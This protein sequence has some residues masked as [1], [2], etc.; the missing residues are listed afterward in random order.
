MQFRDRHLWAGG[1][2]AATS[3]NI[4]NE[5]IAEYIK[6]Q[7]LEERQKGDDFEVDIL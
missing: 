7:S 1:Y 2:F 3:E 5:V 6:N 4:T